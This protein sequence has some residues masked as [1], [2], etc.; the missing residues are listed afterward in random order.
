MSAKRAQRFMPAVA[1]YSAKQGQLNCQ[2]LW[3]PSCPRKCPR[4]NQPG[5]K[6]IVVPTHCRQKISQDKNSHIL[7][8]HIVAKNKFYYWKAIRAFESH[9]SFH[10]RNFWKAIRAFTLC[11]QLRWDEWNISWRA[12]VMGKILFR[13]Y[14]SLQSFDPKC[15]RNIN[16]VRNIM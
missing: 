2:G 14:V 1:L 11:G 3:N 16:N 15:L 7:S 13:A 6:P 10:V 9:P 4:L 5:K 12:C 8:Q